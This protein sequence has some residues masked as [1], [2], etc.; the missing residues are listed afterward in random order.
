MRNFF[1]LLIIVAIVFTNIVVNA[2]DFAPLVNKAWENNQELKSKNF[3]LQSAAQSLN[4]AKALYGP[5]VKFGVQYSL[6]SGGRSIAFPAG[7]LLNPVYSTLNQ[8]TQTNAFPQIS[9]VK[10]QFLPNNFY[11]ARFRVTQPIFYPDLAIN[12][13]LKSE[14]VEQKIIEIKAFK[15]L[16]SKEIM[17]A[18]FQYK[19]AGQAIEIFQSADTLLNE[20]KRSTQSM[21]RNGVALPTAMSRLENQTAELVSQKTEALANHNNAEKLLR[22]LLGINEN[23]PLPIVSNLPQMPT[24]SLDQKG[25]REELLQIRQAIKMQSLGVEQEGNYYIPKI[26]VQLDAG[27]QDFD[28]GWKP[29]VL[30]GLNVDMNIYDSKRHQYRKQAAKANIMATEAQ[31]TQTENQLS[32]Q[33]KVSEENLKAAIIQANVFEARIKAT[34]KLY[35]EVFIKY[36]EGSAGYIQLIDAQTQYTQIRIQHLLANN[37]A[38]MKWAEYVY[39]AAI[40]PIQQ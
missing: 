32:L 34:K 13:K 15:R 27:S 16:I 25:Q 30:L 9:N 28:F 22:F 3:Q 36:K 21:I 4:E 12:K 24:N 20:A 29:Y 40:Y 31:L 17:Q 5:E 26:G 2:Q 6:A 1:H 18:Y 38:W 39:V 23:E 10:E 14:I 37:N 7:D 33:Q 35:D 8:I 19:S 11:D